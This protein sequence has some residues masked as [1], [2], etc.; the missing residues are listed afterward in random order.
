MSMYLYDKQT[1]ALLFFSQKGV[2]K[3]QCLTRC[4]LSYNFEHPSTLA[5]LVEVTES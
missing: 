5:M 3:K 4:H 2:G 1:V